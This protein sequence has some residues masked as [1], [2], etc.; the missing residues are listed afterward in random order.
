MPICAML[1]AL[2]NNSLSLDLK[3]IPGDIDHYL[4]KYSAAGLEFF[5]PN[6]SI[7]QVISGPEPDLTYIISVCM[8]C[9]AQQVMNS[10]LLRSYLLRS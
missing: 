5:K 1:R 6:I 2:K 8:M 9:H 3:I 10:C 7:N 4:A